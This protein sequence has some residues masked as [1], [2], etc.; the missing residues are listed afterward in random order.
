MAIVTGVKEQHDIPHEPGEWVEFRMLSWKQLD[1]ARKARTLDSIN[2][3]R[4]LGG[5]LFQALNANTVSEAQRAQLGPGNEFDHEL[6]LRAAIVSWSYAEPVTP[7]N[8]AALDP[9]TKDWAVSMILTMSTPRSEQ[10]TRDF[11]SASTS[12]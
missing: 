10:E 12:P 1:E 8:L 2:Q 6:L 5:E 7:E 4:A 9:A 3:A 11:F